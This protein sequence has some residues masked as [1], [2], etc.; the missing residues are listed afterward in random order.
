MSIPARVTLLGM[1]LP[2]QIALVNVVLIRCIIN[3]ELISFW[4]EFESRGRIQPRI[5]HHFLFV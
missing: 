3:D 5:R 1:S 4:V 2:A